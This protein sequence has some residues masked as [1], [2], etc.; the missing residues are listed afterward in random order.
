VIGPIL[1]AGAGAAALASAAS[2]VRLPVAVGRR[3]LIAAVAGLWA[4]VMVLALAIVR[5]DTGYAY[6][7][8]QTRPGTGLALRISALWSGAE[9][10]LLLFAAV[11]ATAL[12]I[13]N[14]LAGDV[15]PRWQLAGSGLLVAG[16]VGASGLGANPFERLDL[17]PLVGAG[18][19]PILEPLAMIVHPP[20]LYLG[21]GLALVP[22]LVRDPT[23][24]HRWAAAATAVL[25]VALG[26][27]SAWAY[28]ELGW[29]GWWAWDP[30]ENVA[31]I[32]WLLLAGSLHWK[33]LDRRDLT[34][35][36]PLNAVVLWA[37]CWPAVIGGAA[38]TRTSLRT[39]VH[40]FADAAH[41]SI[42]LWPLTALV[43]VGA[44]LR[45]REQSK[46]TAGRRARRPDQPHEAGQPRTNNGLRSAVPVALAR[47]PQ[48]VLVTAGLVVAAGTYRPFIGGDG[49]A[50]WFYSQMLYPVAIVGLV[51]LGVV[52]LQ[53]RAGSRAMLEWGAPGA[54]AVAVPAS[55]A[56]WNSWYQV[57]LAAAIGFATGMILSDGL[58]SAAR[59][60][61][62]L[63]VV[64][65]LFGALAGTV[66]TESSVRL[67]VGRTAEVDGHTVELISVSI[68]EEEPLVAEARVLVDE[69]YELRPSVAFYPERSLRLPEV[70]TRTR[71]WLD[72]QAVLRDVDDENG[73]LITVL[74]R[75]WNQLVWWGVALLTVAAMLAGF[76]GRATGPDRQRRSRLALSSSDID[77]GG[78]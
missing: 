65:V 50:G 63:G 51:L 55:L 49:T 25:T 40:A 16:F 52:P 43:G 5:L 26:L 46:V 35:T 37:V 21:F 34:G 64:L 12:A 18:M 74:F 24:G 54:A 75:P 47:A 53:A 39:S 11:L 44:G 70:A 41:L 73:A 48:A 4:S 2:V 57:L 67:P 62:H 66:S 71:P 9:G 22:A 42:W 30:I 20:L 68:V 31:L 58:R 19:A 61:A 15:V 3:L 32:V 23:L 59:Q 72:T 76:G 17:P 8:Q 78:A 7:A 56:G 29:G 33:P 60:A 45:I 13:G 38:L 69:A 27:G 77:D 6:V 36:G 1:L 28:V 14:H 10:S